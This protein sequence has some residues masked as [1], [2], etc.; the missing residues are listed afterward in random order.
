MSEEEAE[1]RRKTGAGSV[2][3]A[4]TIKGYLHVLGR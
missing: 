1:E 3:I 4:E 2:F